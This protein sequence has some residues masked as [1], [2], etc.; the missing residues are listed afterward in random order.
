VNALGQRIAALISAQGPVSVAEFLAMALHDPQD[1][2]YATRDPIGSA[3]DFVTAPE[4]S[5]VFGEFLGLWCVQVWNDQGKPA[6]KRLVELGPG[7]GTL[8]NDALRAAKVAP[9]FLDGLEVVLVEASPALTAMQKTLLQPHG[10]PIR[11]TGRFD[12]SFE[13]QPLLLVA[14]EFFDA[15]PIRQFVRTANGWHERMVTLDKQGKLEFAL[16]P[17]PVPETSIPPDHIAAPAGGVYEISA[18]ALALTEEIARIIARRGGGALIVDYGYDRT[19]FG[20]T[21]QAVADHSLAGVLQD[22]GEADLSAHVDFPALVRAAERGGAA[23]FGPVTQAA[24]LE[25]LGA[26]RR[27]EMLAARNPH[28]ATDLASRLERLTA[29]DQMGTLF[30]ALAIVPKTA[31]KPPGF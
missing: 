30:K 2:Y 14:N 17:V 8:M 21:L 25:D 24:F 16:S 6:R 31:A 19:G 29:P 7:R 15:L 28:A 23:A 20:E 9:E 4:I 26:V 22:P 5:Q 3:G 18:P 1:G 10:V 12:P 13:D 11:W 27:I